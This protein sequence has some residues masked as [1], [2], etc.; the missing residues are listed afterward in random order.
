[1]DTFSLQRAVVRSLIRQR[2]TLKNGMTLALSMVRAKPFGSRWDRCDASPSFWNQLQARWT[3]W[4]DNLIHKFPLPERTELLWFEWPSELNPA[5]TS[6]SGFAKLDKTS[7]LFGLDEPRHWPETQDGSTRLDALFEV[8]E[9]DEWL[10]ASGWSSSRFDEDREK[11]S[12][13]YF[14]LSSAAITLLVLNGLPAA[15]LPRALISEGLGVVTGWIDG[16]AVPLGI[17]RESG[18][19]PLVHQ[20]TSKPTTSEQLDPSSYLFNLKKYL[21]AGGDPNW[22]EPESGRSLLMNFSFRDAGQLRML[23]NAGA[24]P[25]IKDRRGYTA[26][27]GFGAADIALLDQLA[28]AGANPR[29]K[30]PSGY[31]LL[32]IFSFD[33][34]CTRAH[35]EWCERHNSGLGRPRKPFLPQ[36]FL[37]ASGVYER[38]RDRQIREMMEWWLSKG[39]SLEAANPLGNTPLCCAILEHAIELEDFQKY[40][41]RQDYCGGSWDYQHDRVAEALLSLGADPNVRIKASKTRLVPKRATPLMVRRYDDTRLVTALLKHGA[42]PTLV[43]AEGKSAL[44]YAKA[45][46]L[47]RRPGN[48]AAAE[49]ASILERAMKKYRPKALVTSKNQQRRNRMH[50]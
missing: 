30:T 19:S 36:H 24:D 41:R 8:P 49:V 28:E 34:R 26:L 15:R 39:F 1:M 10:S 2:P 4:F 23:L 25:R 45:A 20:R 32:Q 38:G 47:S 22:R 35:L 50:P 37:A 44:Q 14:A 29:D 12:P 3:A 9:L 7:D 18:W 21:A 6:V 5:L 43:S 46:S 31:S 48:E 13:G 42:D 17:L 11:L 33:G 16:D 27:Q 40:S